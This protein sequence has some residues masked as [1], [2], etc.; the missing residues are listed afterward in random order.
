MSVDVEQAFS[1]G[2]LVLSHTRSWLTA[3]TTCAVLCLGL[4]S[5]LGLIKDSDIKAVLQLL[6]IEDEEDWLD[7]GWDAI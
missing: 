3:Q 7:D 5:K 6:D 1:H 2:W 4:W